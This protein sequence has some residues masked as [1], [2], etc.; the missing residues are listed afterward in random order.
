MFRLMPDTQNKCDALSVRS[1]LNCSSTICP[2][3]DVFNSLNFAE[4]TGQCNVNK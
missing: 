4:R 1:L 2:T 3:L